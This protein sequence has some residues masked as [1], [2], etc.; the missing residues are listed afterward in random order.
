MPQPLSLHSAQPTQDTR[1]PGPFRLA[2]DLGADSERLGQRAAGAGAPGPGQGRAS[3]QW[4]VAREK[5]RDF[6]MRA[7]MPQM[8]HRRRNALSEE[9]GGAARNQIPPPASRRWQLAKGG[10]L[11]LTHAHGVIALGQRQ[12]MGPF[13]IYNVTILGS[14]KPTR[15]LNRPPQ[16]MQ[17]SPEHPNDAVRQQCLSGPLRRSVECPAQSRR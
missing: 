15:L 2:Q 4:L 14:G 12:I 7:T 13:E 6:G 17:T 10:G 8:S 3:V 1:I 16:G 11:L 5:Q 9:Q